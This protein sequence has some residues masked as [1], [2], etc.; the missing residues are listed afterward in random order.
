M[1]ISAIL[2]MQTFQLYRQDWI[3]SPSG[4][5]TRVGKE[6]GRGTFGKVHASDDSKIVK[7]LR[8]NDQAVEKNLIQ[9]ITIQQKLAEAEP[10]VCPKIYGFGRIE[11][12]KE[13][14][15]IM[16]KCDGTVRDLLK[17]EPTDENFLEYY[18]A[19]AKILARLEKY[20]FSHRDLKSDNVMYKIDK[21]TGKKTF[22]LIDFGFSCATFDGV[23]YASTMYFKTPDSK[24]FRKSR[25]LAQLVFESIYLTKSKNIQTFIQLVLTFNV[26]GKKCVM[27]QGCPPSF[28]AEWT[29]T[30]RFLDNDGVE[31]PN[32]TPEG[33]LKAVA[34][35]RQGGIKS[36]MK[37]FI[38]NPINEECVPEPGA[39]AASALKEAKSPKPH[40][41]NPNVEQAPPVERKTRRK[42]KA[43]KECP[44]GK[45]VNPKT[46]RC[47]TQKTKK[48]KPGKVLNANGRCVKEKKECP[49]GKVLNPATGRCKKEK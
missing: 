20:N 43:A 44:P 45:I 42:P 13:Y 28:I 29:N 14:V 30:Y 40:L 39:P 8:T 19:V 7:I 47:I 15:I 6:L 3:V 16:E 37:G 38:V 2:T 48:C 34:S 1:K 10:D 18:E 41:L 23:Q 26:N 22:L 31:N 11:Q 27:I 33:L 32:T 21:E 4:E 25:D 46:G 24:C 17:K 36:C 12:T 9:E 5:R 49:P 35:Y